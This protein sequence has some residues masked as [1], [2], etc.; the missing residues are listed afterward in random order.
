[1]SRLP[2]LKPTEVI[3]ALKRAG[4]VVDRIKGSHHILWNERTHR[5]VVVPYHNRDMRRSLLQRIIHNAGLTEEE[6]LKLLS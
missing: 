3:R 2:S 4:F 5:V 6:F 1:M